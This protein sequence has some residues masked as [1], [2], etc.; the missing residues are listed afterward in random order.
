MNKRNSYR[1]TGIFTNNYWVGW[2]WKVVLKVSIAVFFSGAVEKFF[3]QRWLSPPRKIGPY[4]YVN[5]T[6]QST[7]AHI[8]QRYNLFMIFLA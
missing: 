8:N 6:E 3:W 4:A 5:N 2:V 1:P 7:A